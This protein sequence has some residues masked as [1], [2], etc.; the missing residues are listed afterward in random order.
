MRGPRDQVAN[1]A[2]EPCNEQQE[3][4]I[5]VYIHWPHVFACPMDDPPLLP[6]VCCPLVDPPLLF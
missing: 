4:F 6:A 3:D 5:P 1:R 2:F